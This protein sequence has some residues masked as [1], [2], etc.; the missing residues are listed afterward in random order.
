MTEQQA[1]VEFEPA[2]VI[3]TVAPKKRNPLDTVLVVAAAIA[4]AGVAFATGRSEEHTSE[5]VTLE[6]RMPSSA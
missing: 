3:P 6:S 5:P 2:P 4:L 1:P